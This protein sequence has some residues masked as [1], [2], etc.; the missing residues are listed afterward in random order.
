MKIAMIG[1]KRIPS[2]EGGIEICV[3][4][5][6]TRMVEAGHEVHVYNRRKKGFKKLRNYKG[7][8]V[9]NVPTIDNKY[10]D[11][12]VAS[13]LATIYA[14]FGQYDVIHYHALGPSVMAF[15]P[16]LLGKKVV[17]TIHGLDWQRAKWGGWGKKYLQLGERVAVKYA[18]FIIV[19][20]TNIQRY[21]Q[22]KYNRAAVY[23]PNGVNN[24][25]I[26]ETR[27]IQNKYGLTKDS[28]IL[29]LARIVPEK[30]L[31]YLI[32][33]Y[34]N[35]DTDLKLVI[36]GD[37]SHTTEYLHRIK[38]MVQ[39][40]NRIIMTGFV[41]GEELEEFYSNALIYVLPS[42][43]EGMPLSL[44]E[45]MSYGNCCVVSNIPEMTEV[46]RDKGIVFNSGDASSLEQALNA[47]I[48]EKDKIGYYK[49]IV[50]ADMAGNFSWHKTMH[51]TIDLVYKTS[52]SSQELLTPFN[53]TANF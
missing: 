2:R 20:S 38:Q 47:L 52:P 27:V 10:L 7:V 34:Q 5:L 36:C 14:L 17:C 22:E 35:L 42:E 6:A 29:F 13:L 23:I 30:G 8:R 41:Q 39:K 44:L 53:N 49:R 45:A 25:Q 32:E 33:A 9:I 3:E 40:D 37:Q 28:Y 24:P 4:E 21:F 26:R 11:A 31:H 16:K 15:I 1:H 12:V 50:A 48:T 43:I 51:K 19:L 18:D 46:I